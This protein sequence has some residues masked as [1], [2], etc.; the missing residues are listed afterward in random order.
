MWVFSAPQV[1]VYAIQPGRGFEQAAHVLGADFA[2][3]LELDGW[4][5]YRRT[6]AARNSLLFRPV[7]NPTIP[8]WAESP[9]IP[10]IL[11]RSACGVAFRRTSRQNR[12]YV[13]EN[14]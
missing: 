9:S 8:E 6:L 12:R 5:V 10:P 2:G 7:P 14:R 13:Y 4:A 11:Q 3:F 1:T